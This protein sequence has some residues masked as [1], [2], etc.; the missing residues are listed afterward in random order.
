MRISGL[1]TLT[2]LPVVT[3]QLT[4]G[5]AWYLLAVSD[6]TIFVVQGSSGTTAGLHHNQKTLRLLVGR[7]AYKNAL[8][9]YSRK[10]HLTPSR[11]SLKALI[12]VTFEKYHIS[13]CVCVGLCVC[14]C[15]SVCVCVCVCRAEVGL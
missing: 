6:F 4:V 11:V 9:N 5:C 10:E 3:E 14:V 15:V 12:Q 1:I 8:K 13:V 2:Y 7:T